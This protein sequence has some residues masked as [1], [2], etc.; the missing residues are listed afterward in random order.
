MWVINFWGTGHLPCIGDT[1]WRGIDDAIYGALG[2]LFSSDY[3]LSDKRAPRDFHPWMATR[4]V[5]WVL[6]VDENVSRSMSEEG[7][8]IGDYIVRLILWPPGHDYDDDRERRLR[9]NSLAFL[10]ISNSFLIQKEKTVKLY[11]L[12]LAAIEF[13]SL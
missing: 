5:S 8:V 10:D 13:S 11:L 2:A 9:S 7:Y 1:Y 4:L 3:T 6:V 12:K